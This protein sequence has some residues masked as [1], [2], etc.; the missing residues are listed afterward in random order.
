M[1]IIGFFIISVIIISCSRSGVP[2]PGGGGPHVITTTDSTDPVIDIF[3]PMANQVIQS[4]DTIKIRGRIT[5]NGLYRG[6]IRITNDATNAVVREQLYEIH[7]FTFY[8][9]SLDHKTFVTAVS[10]YTV[11][12]QF[13]DH[14]LN[15]GTRSVQVKVNP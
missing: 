13:E 7:G 11:T 2:D 9:F 8:N 10:D 4:G 3:S 14:G 5:D 1:K 15:V 6:F 12:V